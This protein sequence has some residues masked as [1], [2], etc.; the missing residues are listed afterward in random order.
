MLAHIFCTP[1]RVRDTAI[2]N[3]VSV[4]YINEVHRNTRT[5]YETRS[6]T[7]LCNAKF[8]EIF[9]PCSLS[10]NRQMLNN[11]INRTLSCI[12]LLIESCSSESYKSPSR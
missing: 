10:H 12:R 1:T 7:T 9:T 8:E 3:E 4:I 11:V 2:E 6:N 5:I